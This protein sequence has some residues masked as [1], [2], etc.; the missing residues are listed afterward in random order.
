VFQLTKIYRHL[1]DHKCNG[2]REYSRNEILYFEGYA[3]W[4][5]PM[6]RQYKFIWND[7]V[8]DVKFCPACGELMNPRGDYYSYG[9]IIIYDAPMKPLRFPS[10]KEF[11]SMYD[12]FKKYPDK[13]V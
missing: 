6:E 12:L 1:A 11:Q 5:S 7:K 3:C 4:C 9:N 2:A 13:I 10:L 8:Y